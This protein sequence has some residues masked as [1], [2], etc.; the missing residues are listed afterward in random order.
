[1]HD[2]SCLFCKIVEGEIPS[3]KVYED[4]LVLAFDDVNPQMPVH[5]LVVPKNHYENLAD[6]IPAQELVAVLE[7]VKK[8]AEAKGISESGFRILSNAGEDAQQV[9]K[10]LHVHVLGG[11][12]MNSGDPSLN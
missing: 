12:K 11:G 4:D 6:E 5:V 7:A 3:T 1:M 10:H 8:V 2:D 9:V